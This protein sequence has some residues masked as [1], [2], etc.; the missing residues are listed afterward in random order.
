MKEPILIAWKDII[1]GDG[2]LW[3]LMA[4]S[5]SVPNGIRVDRFYE[6][7]EVIL[8]GISDS[9]KLGLSENTMLGVVDY[10]KLEE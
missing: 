10:S 4:Y 6:Y 7:C 5:D 8:L 1:K 3:T 9:S 2:K